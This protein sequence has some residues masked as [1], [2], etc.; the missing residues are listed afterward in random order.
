MGWTSY[1]LERGQAG[2]ELKK[3][4]TWENESSKNEL[5]Q[6]AFTSFREYY[7]AVKT[8][9]KATGETY[10]WAFVA[11]VNW[12]RDDYNFS[13]KDLDETM[14]PNISNCP[15]SILKLL[16]PT[17]QIKMITGN[18]RQYAKSWRIRCWENVLAK[19]DLKKITNG[20]IVKFEK[21]LD[22][23]SVV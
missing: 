11:M 2:N 4:L 9:I 20:S 21:E 16:T 14:G 13:Y 10:T 6:G 22:R 23:K 8:T 17:E 3:M 15:L 12:T 7:A 1:H 19:L 18:A 5:V